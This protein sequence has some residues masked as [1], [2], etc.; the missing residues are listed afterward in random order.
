MNKQQNPTNILQTNNHRVERG[1]DDYYGQK[2]IIHIL[3][4]YFPPPFIIENFIFGF[5]SV[6][7]SSEAALYITL[8]VYH[9]NECNESNNQNSIKVFKIIEP[10][11]RKKHY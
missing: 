7:R 2:K 5:F 6:F 11:K 8:H 1:V 3:S 9:I 10:T 4:Q